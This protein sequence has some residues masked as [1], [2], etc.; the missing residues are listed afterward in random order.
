LVKNQKCKKW[1]HKFLYT[2]SNMFSYM[3]NSCTFCWHLGWQILS[4]L[5]TKNQPNGKKKSFSF[6]PF[7]NGFY[8]FQNSYIIYY[9]IKCIIWTFP[10]INVCITYPWKKIEINCIVYYVHF[11]PLRWK[12]QVRQGFKLLKKTQKD[13]YIISNLLLD[14]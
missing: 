11:N 2:T 3:K 5:N 10:N 13:I 6:L 7:Q 12:L 4:L 9:L 1:I 8:S 14:F